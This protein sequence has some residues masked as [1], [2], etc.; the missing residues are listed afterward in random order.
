MKTISLIKWGRLLKIVDKYV[1]VYTYF[2]LE[3]G[4]FAAKY[5]EI[6]GGIYAKDVTA[7]RSPPIFV[8]FILYKVVVL[9]DPP[10]WLGRFTVYIWALNKLHLSIDLAQIWNSLGIPRKNPLRFLFRDNYSE[11]EWNANLLWNGNSHTWF[12]WSEEISFKSFLEHVWS[13][14]RILKPSLSDLEKTGT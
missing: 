14:L 6:R 8:P 3:R 13:S 4:V 12:R 7:I 1:H 5:H 10:Y 11:M 2:S 9:G